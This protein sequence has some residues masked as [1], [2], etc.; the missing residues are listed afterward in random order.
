MAYRYYLFSDIYLGSNKKK[1]VT[2][3]L[4]SSPS[5]GCAKPQY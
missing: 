2:N 3:V 5:A 4:L 1:N